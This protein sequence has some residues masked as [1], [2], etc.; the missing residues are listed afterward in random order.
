MSRTSVTHDMQEIADDYQREFEVDVLDL[1]AVSVWAVKTKRYQ[2]RPMT[3]EQQCKRDLARALRTQHLRD[4]Q[5]REPRRW[6]A[7]H[8]TSGSEQLVLWA[9]FTKAKPNHMRIS[10]QQ[11]RQSTMRMGRT[12]GQKR[13]ISRSPTVFGRLSLR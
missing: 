6:H 11:R 4:A 7:V 1:D 3:L 9:E 10:L 8:V 13:S 12:A 5:G 2:R